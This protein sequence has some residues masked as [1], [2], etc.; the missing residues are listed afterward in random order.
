MRFCKRL[1]TL[2]KRRRYRSNPLRIRKHSQVCD[3]RVH[4]EHAA[5]VSSVS[6]HLLQ[7]LSF[8]KSHPIA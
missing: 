7:L 2:R 3:A 8:T 1:R 6:S 4:V 5:L